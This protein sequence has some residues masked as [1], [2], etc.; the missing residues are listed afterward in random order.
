MKDGRTDLIFR[1]AGSAL[2]LGVHAVP[3]WLREPAR[4]TRRPPLLCFLC[5][6]WGRLARK[7]GRKRLLLRLAPMH[8]YPLRGGRRTELQTRRREGIQRPGTTSAG[9]A[10]NGAHCDV[11]W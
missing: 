5:R 10:A 11:W 7:R 4:P 3:R 1:L 8:D 6:H 9:A 2:L